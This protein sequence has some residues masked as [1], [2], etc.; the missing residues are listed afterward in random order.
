MF[1]SSSKGTKITR[2]ISWE[3]SSLVPQLKLKIH[4][5]EDRYRSLKTQILDLIKNE[6]SNELLMHQK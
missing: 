2:Y 5:L 3:V 6:D 1:N 4:I